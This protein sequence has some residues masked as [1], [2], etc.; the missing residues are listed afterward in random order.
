MEII[1]INAIN[2]LV[3]FFFIILLKKK[4]YIDNNFL[5]LL[6]ITS[7]SPFF[8]NYIYPYTPDQSVYF[9]L[10]KD[11]RSFNYFNNDFINCTYCRLD[12]FGEKTYLNKNEI[13][14]DVKYSSIILSIIPIPFI[15]S[16]T[17]IGLINKL[18]FLFIF[19]YLF[20]DKSLNKYF[21]YFI[22]FYPSFL[23]Y[24]SMGLRETLIVCLILLTLNSLI[25]NNIYL[26]LFSLIILYLIK[27]SFFV[28]LLFTGIS[29][30]YLF[31]LNVDLIKKILF[32]IF[33]LFVFYLINNYLPSILSGNPNI[34]KTLITVFYEDLNLYRLVNIFQNTYGIALDPDAH[35]YHFLH[36]QFYLNYK[37]FI[38]FFSIEFYLQPLF[39]LLTPFKLNYDNVYF[40]FK[41]IENIIIFFLMIYT[42][43]IA[44]KN[45]KFKTFFWFIIFYI[46]LLINSL[47]FFNIGAIDRMRM[48]II[49]AYFFIFLNDT[50]FHYNHNLL[51]EF[52][53]KRF[54]R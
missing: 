47:V 14:P 46:F 29:Y 45:S 9:D 33:S 42:A 17:S 21:F 3:I 26:F 32:M 39:F 13:A 54:F 6:I 22:F 51:L 53:K 49:I 27:F 35:Q 1:F 41:S 7:L 36:Y 34:N 44:F 10:I 30:F 18:L 12:I 5:I 40:T 50:N 43:L 25:K 24:S 15:V 8:I 16:L 52:F 38:D 28:L 2:Y 19:I 4:N 23:F 11:I 37:S 48:P 31:L 20:R